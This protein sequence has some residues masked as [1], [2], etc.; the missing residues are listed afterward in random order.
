[1]GCTGFRSWKSSFTYY[2]ILAIITQSEDQEIINNTDTFDLASSPF[3]CGTSI[4]LSEIQLE[5]TFGIEIEDCNTTITA[6]G[7]LES[8]LPN[9]NF[10]DSSFQEGPSINNGFHI[11]NIPVGLHRIK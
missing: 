8:Y 1:M 9:F 3:L 10:L 6:A 2:R 4:G 11:T 7:E 5:R